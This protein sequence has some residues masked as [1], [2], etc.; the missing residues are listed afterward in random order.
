M[1][2]TALRLGPQA[3]LE[4][5]EQRGRFAAAAMDLKLALSGLQARPGRCRR[6]GAAGD[7]RRGVHCAASG[8]QQWIHPASPALLSCWRHPAAHAAPRRPQVLHCV[9]PPDVSEDV[10]AMQRQLAAL[11]FS[12]SVR[13]EQLTAALLEVGQG[14]GLQGGAADLGCWVLSAGCRRRAGGGPEAL[15]AMGL[16]CAGSQQARRPAPPCVP[17]LQPHTPCWWRCLCICIKQPFPPLPCRP[18][19]CC[20]CASWTAPPLWRRCWWRGWG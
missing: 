16:P 19:C 13:Q 8:F 18:W 5:E 12:S 20:T 10:A 11:R 4:A 9:A 15:P 2:F 17:P 6:G 3:V 1:R 7:A 14:G